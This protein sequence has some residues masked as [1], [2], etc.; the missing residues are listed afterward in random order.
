MR[1]VSRVA[2]YWGVATRPRSR[3]ASFMVRGSADNVRFEVLYQRLAQGCRFASD[4]HV[5]AE[6]TEERPDLTCT[7]VVFPERAVRYVQVLLLERQRCWHVAA[8]FSAHFKAKHPP[9]M[10]R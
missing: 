5:D 4:A 2:L 6:P 1:A 9:R 8:T 10:E 7:N 3:P